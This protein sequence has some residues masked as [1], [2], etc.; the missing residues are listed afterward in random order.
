V[1]DRTAFTL[2]GP[3]ATSQ[4]ISNGQI[5]SFLW[6][7]RD[8]IARL[9]TDHSESAFAILAPA[10]EVGF[11]LLL[12]HLS[13]ILI[14]GNSQG[15]EREYGRI[16]DPLLSSLRRELGGIIARL[17]KLDFGSAMDGGMGMGMAGGSSSMYM[18][19]LIDKLTF[20]KTEIFAN[21]SIGEARWTWS[22]N[23]LDC[24]FSG[25]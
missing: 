15:L 18:R 5:A 25:V 1:R 11:L 2:L 16:T 21:F 7:T 4:Q 6:H 8:R 22:V 23:F 14:V 3:T 17:H 13:C 10:L 19:E 9:K 24:G 12:L 20:V